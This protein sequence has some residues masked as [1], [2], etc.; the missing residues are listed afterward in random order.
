MVRVRENGTQGDGAGGLIDGH[1]RK[2]QRA[3]LREFDAIAGHQFHFCFTVFL[4]QRTAGQLLFQTQ[5]I[6]AGLRNIHVDRVKLLHSCQRSGLSVLY[7]SAF[8]DG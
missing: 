5:E 2:F 3:S 1:V 4:F 7:Q 6:V 8:S